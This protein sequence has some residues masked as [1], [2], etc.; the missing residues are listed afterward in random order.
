MASLSY[1]ILVVLLK[2]IILLVWEINLQA[3]VHLTLLDPYPNVNS[4]SFACLPKRRKVWS[5][6]LC[7]RAFFH[8]H[9]FH[10]KDGKQFFWMPTKG[11]AK[12]T[13]GVSM[14]R[15]CILCNVSHSHGRTHN[16]SIQSLSHTKSFY[17]C[18][19][20]VDVKIINVCQ[21]S[22]SSPK[23]TWKLPTNTL[24]ISLTTKIA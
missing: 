3:W 15:T 23:P 2:K 22:W 1:Q 20:K 17:Q 10:A 21:R 14:L 4:P 7:A 16:L 12:L 8:V 13:Q 18:G 6:T 5:L 11:H 24:S 9:K 19:W